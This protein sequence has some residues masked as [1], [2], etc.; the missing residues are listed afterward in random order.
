MSWQTPGKDGPSGSDEAMADPE[1]PSPDSETTRVPIGPSDEPVPPPPDAVT[2]LPGTNDPV[3]PPPPAAGLISAQPVGWTGPDGAQS[4]A[5]PPG[6]PPVAWAPPVRQVTAQVVDGLVIAGTFTR[7]V[8]YSI[9][10]LFL[11]L[12]NL[13]AIATLGLFSS[14][15]ETS[16]DLVISVAFVVVDFAYFVG[17]WRSPWHATLGMRLLSLRVLAAASAATLSFNDALLRWIALSGAVAILAL[18]PRVAGSL[19]LLSAVWVIILL[20][21]TATNP[22]HQGLHDR[23]ARSVVVQPAPGGSGL[24][25]ATCLVMVVLLFVVVPLAVLAFAGPQLQ[26]LMRQIGESV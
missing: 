21:T 20:V 25:V 14:D 18:V 26:D 1:A 17:L 6:G 2:P 10:T 13:A 12:L 4:A 16:L 7:L 23:W 8:A 11:G 9:D 15:R 5:P 19:G 3:P 24:A 22:L